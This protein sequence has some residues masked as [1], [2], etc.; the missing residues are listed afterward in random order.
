MRIV[1]SNAVHPRDPVTE[2]FDAIT[3]ARRSA[4]GGGGEWRVAVRSRTGQLMAT[5]ILGSFQQVMAFA[6][7]VRPLGYQMALNDWDGAD[8]Y[9]FSF[10]RR[11]ANEAFDPPRRRAAD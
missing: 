5:F 3:A 1:N 11:A 6:D 8:S 4:P 10:D 7:R 2:V 9:D